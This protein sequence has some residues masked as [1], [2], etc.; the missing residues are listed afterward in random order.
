MSNPPPVLCAQIKYLLLIDFPLLTFLWF[1]SEIQVKEYYN[2]KYLCEFQN[3]Y[4]ILF[5]IC[6][7]TFK[8]RGET[9]ISQKIKHKEYLQRSSE[10]KIS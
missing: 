6:I 9:S 1:T 10:N 5:R 4:N 2:G 3:L 8:D 7:K